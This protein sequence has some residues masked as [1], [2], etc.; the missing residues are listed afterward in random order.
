MPFIIPIEYARKFF[1]N[2][3]CSHPVLWAYDDVLVQ[4]ERIVEIADSI[5]ITEVSREIDATGL[6]LLPGVIAPQVH[7]KVVT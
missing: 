2:P 3:Q 5:G 7:L 4:D 1:A 6:V